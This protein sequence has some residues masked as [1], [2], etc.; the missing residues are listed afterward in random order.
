MRNRILFIILLTVS[1]LFSSNSL[2]S[3]TP[4]STPSG[5]TTTFG[6][7]TVTSMI[8][9]G[10]RGL[11]FDGSDEKFRS[12]LNYR[13]GFRLWN[14]SFRMKAEDGKGK[15]FDNLSVTTSGWSADPSG[16]IRVGMDKAGA[17]RFDANV[18]QV[19]LINRVN[20]LTLGYH[21]S[22]T[23]RNF[24]DFDLTLFPERETFRLRFGASFNRATGDRGSSYRT[25]DVFPIVEK[26]NSDADDFRAGFDSKL[27]GFK[28]TL[29]GGMRR[30][31][32]RG[33]F[34]IESRQV[35][36]AGSCFFGIC[37]SP[38]DV[39]FINRLEKHNP[40]DGDTQYG[41]FTIQRTFAQKLDL[42]GRFI[43]SNTDN[44]FGI[45]ENVSWDGQL[46]Y[47]GTSGS[48]GNSPNLFVDADRYNIIGGS[49]RPQSRGDIGLTYAVNDSFRLSNTFTFDQYNSFGDTDYYQNFT[50]RCQVVSVSGF[51]P[52]VGAPFV[53]GLTGVSYLDT[54]TLYWFSYGFK[55][56]TNTLEGDYQ[57]SNKFSFNLGYRFTHRKVALAHVN[58]IMDDLVNRPL[59]TFNTVTVGGDEEENSAHILLVGAKIRPSDKW[60][61]FVDAEHGSADNAFIRLSNYNYTNYR[62]RSNWSYKRLNFNVSGIIRNNEN[63]SRTIDYTNSTGAITLP[64]FDINANVRTR[65]FTAYVDYVPD[66][67][68]TLST[69]YTYNYLTSKTDLVVPLSL[70]A[71]LPPNPVG[72]SGFLRGFS[73]FYMKD[74]YFFV[75]LSG[76]PTNRVS[77]YASYRYNNDK[78]Q[79]SQAATVMERFISSYPF[80]S[81]MPEARISIK[82]TKN[83]DWNL[84]YQYNNYKESIQYGYFPYN[85]LVNTNVIPAN[86]TYPTNQNYRAHLPYTSLRIYFGG[87]R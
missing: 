81:H 84:G 60:S 30:F 63:P 73:E 8:E 3:Q 59:N 17:Y 22:D 50:A 16:F 39:N 64:A 20:N 71:A 23:R 56:F 13:P 65:V 7:Y 82:L 36:V 41:I 79:G 80:K 86:A 42:T 77:F 29:T 51:C 68:W 62:V 10:L 11:R 53:A 35:G 87:G 19:K 57:F 48:T 45:A 66:P 40:T 37:I 33:K 21:L 76:Q 44:T 4:T 12:D 34:L 27:A 72:N 6:G 46:R 32:D 85:E 26:L 69:G 31:R 61:I 67:R 18:R 2:Y 38:T 58:R 9:V 43:Y 28:V 70:N 49:K 24:G 14:S 5:D 1:L 78:G 15:V 52:A 25:R 54:R 75:D 74:G 47:T 83:V 55:R